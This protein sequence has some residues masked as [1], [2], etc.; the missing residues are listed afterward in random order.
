MY[1]AYEKDTD[2]EVGRSADLYRL[3]R[4][5]YLRGYKTHEVIIYLKITSDDDLEKISNGW[6]DEKKLVEDEVGLDAP[7]RELDAQTKN[8]KEWIEDNGPWDVFFNSEG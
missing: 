5:L 4:V 1:I 6:K 7:C 3:G 8:E 2:G